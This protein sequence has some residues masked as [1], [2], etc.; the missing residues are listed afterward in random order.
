MDYTDSIIAKYIDLI[1]SATSA[2]KVFYQGEPLRIANSNLPC[3]IISKTTTSVVPFNN[4]DDEHSI[5]LRIT[6]ITDVRNDLSTDESYAK[7]VEGVKTLYEIMEGREANY[8]LK[9]SSILDIL[10]SNINLDVS[11]NLRTDLSTATRVDYGTT[12]RDRDPGEWT[13]EARLEFT[14]HFIQAR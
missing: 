8:T 7:V 5:G 10:R 3:C 12:M 13:I 14:C 6:V 11:K 2:I 1:Q 9:S 4:A